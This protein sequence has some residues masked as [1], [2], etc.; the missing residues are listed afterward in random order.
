MLTHFP[1]RSKVKP[2]QKLKGAL[3]NSDEPSNSKQLAA[4]TLARCVALVPT[5]PLLTGIVVQSL[6]A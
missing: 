3:G 5:L 2:W 4:Y 1:N 6:L